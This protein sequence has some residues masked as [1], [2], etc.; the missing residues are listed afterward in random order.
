MFVDDEDGSFSIFPRT[1]ATGE[2]EYAAALMLESPDA[3]T[4]E[5]IMRSVT[6]EVSSERNLGPVTWNDRCWT[7]ENVR[8]C[9]WE[10]YE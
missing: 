4:G 9:T 1:T 10:T 5:A 7:S 6:G 8:F 3:G 2:T